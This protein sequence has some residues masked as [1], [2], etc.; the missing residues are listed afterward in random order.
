MPTLFPRQ[1]LGLAAAALLCGCGRGAPPPPNLVLVVVDTLREDHLQ[2]YGYDAHPTTP[3]LQEFAREAVTVDGLISVSSWTMPSMATLLTGLPPSGHGV[4]RMMG[5]AS[6][7]RAPDTLGQV[8]GDHG[9]ATA[10]VMSNFLLARARGVGFERGFQTYDDELALLQN[11][12]QGSTAAR[13]ADKGIAWLRQRDGAQPYFLALHFFD[14]HASY[15]D[16]P[17]VDFTDPAYSGWVQGGL[18]NDQYRDHEASTGEA[19][20]RQLAAYYDEEVHA[21]D[22]AFGRVLAE[23]RARPDWERTLVVFTADHGEELGERGHI[24]H[25][26]TL[27]GELVDLPLLVRLPGGAHGGE[28]WDSRGLSQLGLYPTL[29]ELCEVPAPAGRAPSFAAQLR[30]S[31]RDGASPAPVACE[32][33]F[34]PNRT[35][36]A[37]KFTRKRAVIQYPYKLILD[38]NEDRASLYDLA[39]DPHEL[40]DLSGDAAHAEALARLRQELERVDW[41]KEQP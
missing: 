32:V 2:P 21:V 16:H 20:R 29:L 35:D 10:C 6:R 8:L 38:R 23:L 36:Q 12:H 3:Q 15:Q 17:D 24:G 5:D 19:D 4:M 37:E 9:Y 30:G 34:V 7:L 28:R 25:T 22:Q 33:D 31:G 27:H 40:Q 39:Q 13:V 18:E 1:G 11:P 26:Q 14:P 41:W